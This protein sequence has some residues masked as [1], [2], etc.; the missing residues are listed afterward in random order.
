VLQVR[1]VRG[2]REWRVFRGLPETLYRADPAYVVPLRAERR[3]QLGPHNPYFRHARWQPFIAWEGARPVGRVSAQVDALYE[4]VH[5]VREGHFGLLDTV[6]DARAVAALL[7]AAAAWLHAAG[8]TRVRGPFNLSINEECGLLVHGFGHPPVIMMGHAPP[9]LGSHVE[10]AGFTRAKDLIAYRVDLGY[11]EPAASRRLLESVGAHI[12][13]RPF[14]RRRWRAELALLRGI[15]NAAWTGNWGFVPF[16]PEEFD[17]LGPLVRFVVPPEQ[18]RIA[19]LDGA[20][21]GMIAVL[22]NL[23][24]LIADLDGRLLPTG[25]VRL[26]WRLWRRTPAGVRVALMGV[27]PHLQKSPLGAAVAFL[28]IRNARTAAVRHGHRWAEMSWILEDNT[29]MRRIIEA[30]GS[31]PYKRYRLYERAL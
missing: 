13:D 24:E 29:G 21:V 22:P 19:E 7:D 23:N 5:G 26:A 1:P 17:A 20:P 2:A 6:D 11:T 30:L 10:A 27:A 18:V 4:D 12:A 31:E 15:F 3:L 28:L 14:E 16:T 8:C 9:Y 25:L